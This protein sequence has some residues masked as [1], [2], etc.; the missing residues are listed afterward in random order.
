MLGTKPIF[1]GKTCSVRSL[2]VVC[3]TF[4]T[5][6]CSLASLSTFCPLI[7]WLMLKTNHSVIGE[8]NNVSNPWKNIIVSNKVFIWCRKRVAAD[9]SH[10]FLKFNFFLSG[11]SISGFQ[12]QM[13]EF[14]LGRVSDWLGNA[15]VTP[16]G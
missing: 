11:S 7:Q 4:V 6:G 3:V 12:A 9:P 14:E 15:N 13:A 10:Y 16:G 5:L 2:A 8:M 1:V